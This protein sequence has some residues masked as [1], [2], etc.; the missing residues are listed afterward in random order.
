MAASI[1]ISGDSLVVDI[2]GA[3]KLWALK[4]RPAI[5]LAHVAGAAPAEA[6]AREWLHGIRVGGTHIPGVISAGRFYSHGTWVLWD[7]HD[8]AKAIGIELRDEHYTKLVI[9]AGNPEEQI[10]KI[11]EATQMAS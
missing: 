2:E 3:D 5:P 10:R 6:E 4:S 9:Q 1:S 8:P 7:V 11:R